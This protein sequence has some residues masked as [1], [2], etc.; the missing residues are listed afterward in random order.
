MRVHAALLSTLSLLPTLA[1][2]GCWGECDPPQENFELIDEPCCSSPPGGR[3][4][5]PS[6][7]SWAGWTCESAC[8][9]VYAGRRGWSVMEVT[10]CE[11]VLPEDPDGPG[12]EVR[13]TCTGRGIEYYCEGRRPLD[14]V[15]AADEGCADP[16]G[17][18]FAAVAYLEAS[19]VAAF[20]ELA[21]WLTE[22]GAPL[23]LVRRCEA[24]AADE[25]LHT[26]WM[27]RLAEQHGGQAP[28]LTRTEARVATAIE[29]AR[30]NAVEGCVHECFAALMAAVRAQTAEARGLRRIFARIAADE[31]RHGELAWDLHTW[32]LGQLSEE[33][34]AEVT[35]LRA[36]ALRGLEARAAAA[37]VGVPGELGRLGAGEVAALAERFASLLAA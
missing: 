3:P 7:T 11:L 12:A 9:H 20:E 21:G 19:S 30:H 24:A 4:L 16:L 25:R 32:L 23:E 31:A 5:P 27:T 36:A 8:R 18:Y 10:S 28:R 14:H 22:R 6:E 29:V 15:E 2:Y 33:E 1:A 35:A 26:R 13:I 37:Q 34:A 17:R